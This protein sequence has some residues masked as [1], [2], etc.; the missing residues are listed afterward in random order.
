MTKRAVVYIDG[1]NL[2]HG[3]CDADLRRFLWL[4]VHA[5]AEQF[6]I[7]G[8]RLVGTKYFTFRTSFPADRVRRQ[9]MY[10]DVLKSRG[11]QVIEGRYD[12]EPDTCKCGKPYI[13]H[14]EKMTDVNIAVNVLRDAFADAF[15]T[16]IIVTGDADQVPTIGTVRECFPAKR[17]VVLFPPKRASKHLRMAAHVALNINENHLR[18][19]QL[20]EIIS[21]ASGQL[22]S[23]PTE[24]SAPAAALPPITVS[25]NLAQIVSGTGPEPVVDQSGRAQ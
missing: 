13:S 2:Y 9:T 23:R 12:G 8:Q 16:A 4:D 20:P 3:M 18:A 22:L 6:T 1:Y 25:T 17:T 21:L 11:I 14:A 10:I 24:W 7:P 15:D 19:A 5:M